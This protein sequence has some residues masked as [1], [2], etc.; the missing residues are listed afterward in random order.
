MRWSIELRMFT[1]KSN[2]IWTKQDHELTLDQL[3]KIL[4]KL[5]KE[6]GRSFTTS[7]GYMGI[8][9]TTRC[10]ECR[11][12]F[13]PDHWFNLDFYKGMIGV[14]CRGEVIYL[15]DKDKELEKL[16]INTAPPD[17]VSDDLKNRVLKEIEGES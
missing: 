17:V 9:I 14:Y 2:P 10:D 13:N 6:E 5:P 12:W 8:V 4:R 3:N 11:T 15:M 16:I 7:K 1:E